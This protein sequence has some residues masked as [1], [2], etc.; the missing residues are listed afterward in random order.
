MRDI[1]VTVVIFGILPFALA[2]PYVGVLLWTWVSFMNPHRL[3]WGFAFDFPFAMIIAIV[4]LIGLLISREPK[5]IPW[6]RETVILFVF[7]L[8]MVITTIFSVYPILAWPQLDKVLK[9][10]LMVFVTMMVMQSKERLNLLVWVMTLSLAFYGVKGGIF[11]ISHGGVY[12]V[13]GPDNTFIGGDNE[14]GLALIMTIPLLRYLQLTTTR[15]W[16][17]HAMTAVIM[18]CALAAIGSQSRGA[19]LG[20]VAM[21]AFFWIKSRSRFFT[22]LLTAVA[23]GLI[24]MVMP[25]AWFDRMSTIETYQQDASAEGRI[26]AWKMAFNLAKDRP[27]GGG[28]NAFQRGMFA[29]YAPDP[30]NVHDSHSIYFEVLGEHGFFGLALFLLLGLMTWRTASWIIKRARDDPE[31]RWAGDLAAMVQVSLVGYAG[32]GAF[33]GLANFDLY[34]TLIAVVVLCKT[35]LLSSKAV[36]QVDPA[37][38]RVDQPSKFPRSG[39]EPQH[40]AI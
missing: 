40:E 28:F 10:Q 11:T 5:K 34:Y 15:F 13:R 27:L 16:L 30:N 20:M 8:W 23:A 19:M 7:V 24:L 6:T 2:R 31:N 29:V 22:V 26:N 18:L 35:I 38:D 4:T 3:C 1:F 32:A 14:M 12:H 9:I 25:Q 17:R 37:Q 39:A 33:L 36:P 21:G